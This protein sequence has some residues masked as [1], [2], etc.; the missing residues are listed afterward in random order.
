[1]VKLRKNSEAFTA[2][3]YHSVILLMVAVVCL[4]LL[5]FATRAEG[6]PSAAQKSTAPASATVATVAIAEMIGRIPVSGTLVARQEVLIYPQVNG[7][8]IDTLEV[9]VGDIVNAGDVLATLNARTLAS[10]LAQAQAEY[11]RAEAS[12]GQAQSQIISA[13]ATATRTT[14]ALNRA[15]R[16][17]NAGTATQSTLDQAVADS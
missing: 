10:E 4:T 17:K 2:Q 9:D 16:L 6:T 3:D 7:S 15:Q 12:V 13:R 5:P 8:T 14:A 1:M 11:A